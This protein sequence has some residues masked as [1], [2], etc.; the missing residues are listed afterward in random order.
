MSEDKPY[1]YKAIQ[2]AAKLAENQMAFFHYILHQGSMTLEEKIAFLDQKINEGN[3]HAKTFLEIK[4]DLQK[5]E[6]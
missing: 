4:K 5:E 2:R 6:N 1:H 3:I